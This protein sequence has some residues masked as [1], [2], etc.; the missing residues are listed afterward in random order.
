MQLILTHSILHSTLTRKLEK[1]F[2]AS[3]KEREINLKS[4]CIDMSMIGLLMMKLVIPLNPLNPSEID[5]TH[6]KTTEMIKY[7]KSKL[8]EILKH[9]QIQNDVN[10]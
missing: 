2:H 3:V 5:V 6:L 7:T 1:F 9:I 8:A 10:F 4:I